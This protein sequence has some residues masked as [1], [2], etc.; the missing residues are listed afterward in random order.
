MSFYSHGGGSLYDVISCL[1][2]WSHVP[3]GGVSVSGQMFLIGG[4]SVRGSLS[5][6]SLSKGISVQG[7]LCTR[8][9]SV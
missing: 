5:R 4:V 6:G 7:G 8:R 9:I 2:A 3:S 1:A